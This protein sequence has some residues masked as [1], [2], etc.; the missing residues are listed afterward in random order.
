MSKITP[1]LWFDH[2]AEEAMLFYC[3]IFPNSKAGE[4]TRSGMGVGGPPP[5]GNVTSVTFELDGQPFIA[6]NGG[7]EFKFSPAISFFVKCQTQDEVNELWEKLS[8]GGQEGQCG[9]LRDQF[10]VWW[11]IIPDALGQM[12]QDPDKDKAQN[13][14][15]AM[16][17]MEKID[18]GTLRAAY[19]AETPAAKTS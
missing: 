18:I 8:Q 14:M 12:L 6:F 19:D 7:P 11:Q 16:L 9:W 2:Q 10:G 1:F 15:Q 17:Q 13:V 3:S 4:V 5:A